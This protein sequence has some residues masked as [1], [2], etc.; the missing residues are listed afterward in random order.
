MPVVPN[1]G[2]GCPLGR[3][4]STLEAPATKIA[5]PESRV[6]V[7]KLCGPRK[8]TT[9]PASPKVEST[10]PFELN[11][12]IEPNSRKLGHLGVQADPAMTIL[13]SGWTSI[14]FAEATGAASKGAEAT[15][16]I[17]MYSPARGRTSAQITQF[18][19]GHDWRHL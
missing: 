18:F 13:P 14:E 7:E 10:L 8:S 11:L 5:P 16:M 1:D 9:V 4:L 2:L 3:K 12:T 17:P 15:A 19:F 6:A